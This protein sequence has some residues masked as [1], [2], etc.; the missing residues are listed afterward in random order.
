MTCHPYPATKAF[1]I[2]LGKAGL[3]FV[4]HGDTVKHGVTQLE[5]G[6][7]LL[8]AEREDHLMQAH[9]VTA[10]EVFESF[11]DP[12]FRIQLLGS[13]ERPGKLYFGYGRAHNGRLLLITFRIF[14]DRKVW[15]ITARD[16]SD[17]DK[18]KY[19]GS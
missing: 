11:E 2:D 4:I 7:I 16:M 8:S 6:E 15:I 13:D 14:P 3:T 17:R 18:R 9:Q 12:A 19:R 10:S 5:F 1:K